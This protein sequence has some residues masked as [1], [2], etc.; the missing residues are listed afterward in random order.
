[1]TFKV[2]CIGLY[3]PY[4]KNPTFWGSESEKLWKPRG[5]EECSLR[6]SHPPENWSMDE[7]HP[8]PCILLLMA[9]IWRENPPGMHETL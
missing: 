9:E 4:T 8:E 6:G 3:K 5:M 2:P 7:G 1:M